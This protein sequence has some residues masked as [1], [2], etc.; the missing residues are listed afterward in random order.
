MK[1]K[2][3]RIILISL[4]ATFALSATVTSSLAWFKTG[5][6]VDFGT[7]ESGHIT[8]TTNGGYFG[9][10]P[11]NPQGTYGF[12]STNPFVISTPTHLYNLAWL[13]F[14]GAFNDESCTAY[15]GEDGDGILQCYFTVSND[16]DMSG[17]ILPPIGTE[18]YPFFGYFNGGSYTISNL[19]MTNDLAVS[20]GGVTTVGTSFANQVAKPSESI[21]NALPSTAI[22][23]VVGFF[24]V[25]GDIHT[26]NTSIK[27][28][29]YSTFT[30]SMVNVTIKNIT[31]QSKT[32]QTLIGLAAGYVD[33]TMSGVK[34]DGNATLDVAGE[35][36]TASLSAIT[37]KIS[38]YGLVGFTT[39]TSRS[40]SFKQDLSAYY[41]SDDDEGQGDDWGGSIAVQEI[42]NRLSSIR[43]SYASLTNSPI[44]EKTKTYRDGDTLVSETTTKTGD[45]SVYH[46]NSE[47]HRVTYNNKIGSFQIG[48]NPE[49]YTD[50]I[51]YLSG[52]HYTKEV[53][54]VKHQY[55]PITDGTNYL[56]VFL[57]NGSS[58]LFT[59]KTNEEECTFWNMPINGSGKIY[60]NDIRSE[61]GGSSCYLS[62]TNG[63]LDLT[64][65]SS[66]AT[67]WTVT[68]SDGKLSIVSG[69]YHLIYDNE[70]VVRDFT[71]TSDTYYTIHDN[72]STPRYFAPGT[73]TTYLYY[74]R[75]TTN[76]DEQ[77]TWY[78]DTTNQAYYYIR[79]GASRYLM[80]RSNYS[81][82]I[83]NN[84]VDSG[85]VLKLST[86]TVTGTGYLQA[87]PSNQTY[88]VKFNSLSDNGWTTS[89]GTSGR[90]TFIIE[91]HTI[92]YNNV[93]NILDRL[94]TYYGPD[95][96]DKDGYMDYTGKDVTYFPLNVKS[97]YTPADNNTGYIIGGSAYTASSNDY[98]YGTVRISNMYELSSNIT[99]YSFD[100]NKLNNVKT[101]NASGNV[102]I[103]DSSNTYQRYAESKVKVENILKNQ[104]SSNKVCGLHFMQNLIDKKNLVTAEYAQINT[105]TYSNYQFPASS[106]DFNLKERGFVNFFAGT[107]G[108]LS[109][110]T[111]TT[112]DSFFSLHQIRR[113]SNNDIVSIDEIDQI[114][115]DGNQDHAYI[116]KLSNGKYTIPYS[117][118]I[119]N[120]KT[121]YVIDTTTPLSTQYPNEEFTQVDSYPSTYSVVF[122]TSWIKV[123]NNFTQ[124]V[125]YYFEIPINCGEFCLG[126]VDGSTF[127][128]YLVY[129][130]I[131][132]FDR[133][134]DKVEAYHVTTFASS[135]PY[136]N[137]VDFAVVGATGVG[138][139]SMGIYL[140]N[141]ISGDVVVSFAIS[142]NDITIT[143]DSDN[144]TYS[145]KGTKY[146][147][148]GGT[149][150]FKVSGNSPGDLVLPPAGGMRL[151]HITV[152]AVDNSSWV[153]DILDEL[154]I[155][156]T[157]KSTTYPR[158]LKDG[159]TQQPTAIPASVNEALSDIRGL[160]RIVTFTRSSGVAEF[161]TT[162]KYDAE[163]RKVVTAT[164]TSDDL[165]GI[166][167]SVSN[168]VSGYT[169]KMN[170]TTVS[171]G[172]TYQP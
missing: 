35:S 69:N 132:A 90:I 28:A 131:G 18:L 49:N 71:K 149:D 75:P 47:S 51:H 80:L 110:Q 76:A 8:A 141:E 95:T 126:S 3:S 124:H 151:I 11:G 31:V 169:V 84:N 4:L 85:R 81:S 58:I 154:N 122:D 164:V 32:T 36:T 43:S 115:S 107:Y 139:E 9:H 106:I 158:I 82:A 157:I 66:S 33:G 152:E 87:R 52:G 112:I 111:T 138:G 73:D 37:D 125:M 148:S 116:Y 102:T 98:G 54:Q 67:T 144:A 5:N 92:T 86:G 135:V 143:D 39:K 21:L 146:S 137:G 74:L 108:S 119:Y 167:I 89:T 155:D 103:N 123:H 10:L 136:P 147:D 56:S 24:G 62:I 15:F 40:G 150:K 134:N 165:A 166:T 109:G 91:S 114:L 63:I 41:D 100:T 156:G 118:N 23:R 140:P 65:S 38:D 26:I 129:L 133:D 170:G 50:G 60:A 77:I 1:R 97:D 93:D 153:I 94:T 117:Y 113:D 105:S 6:D 25:I 99:N 46:Y 172:S 163:T 59:N 72:N 128:A 17:M 7:G 13:Q 14:I 101:Y 127:G 88:Y 27:P 160:A 30:P 120:Q 78:Y 142:S 42:Y 45:A 57:F 70:W 55:R 83:G 68:S 121:K 34:I 64:T 19:K 79:D 2:T 159:V 29:D 162:A 171:N 20:N 145:F 96:T 44:V 161:D 48:K 53:E 61:L 16:I 22:P 130:D 168:L 104:E 12:S